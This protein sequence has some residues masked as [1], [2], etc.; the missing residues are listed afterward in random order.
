VSGRSWIFYQQTIH[1]S[2]TLFRLQYNLATCLGWITVHRLLNHAALEERGVLC[3]AEEAAHTLVLA[4]GEISSGILG[5]CS[6]GE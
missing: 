4:P 1:V 2:T 3:L 6:P 5:T